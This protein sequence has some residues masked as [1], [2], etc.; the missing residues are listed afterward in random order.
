[1]ISNNHP[2]FV[3]CPHYKIIE[4]QRVGFPKS[5]KIE[6]RASATSPQQRNQSQVQ[7]TGAPMPQQWNELAFQK[8]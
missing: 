5:Q 8:M 4:V 1:M 3:N 6:C 2:S 7:L